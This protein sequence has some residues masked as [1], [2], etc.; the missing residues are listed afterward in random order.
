[1]YDSPICIDPVVIE[2][3]HHLPYLSKVLWDGSDNLSE[4]ES[5]FVDM[6]KRRREGRKWKRMSE[7]EKRASVLW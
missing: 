5:V 1:M 7:E 4:R 2:S 3:A 6:L